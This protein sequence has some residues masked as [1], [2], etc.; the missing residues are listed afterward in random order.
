MNTRCPF[1]HREMEI[2]RS[3]GARVL[4]LCGAYGQI[5]LLRDAHHFREKAGKAL[6]IDTMTA[7]PGIEVVD[8]GTVF[9]AEGEPAI[10]Q[11]ARKP[12]S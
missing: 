12:H 4:C 7:G 5:D 10:I 3:V 1:C 8:G 2:S 9:E 11:W 6:G